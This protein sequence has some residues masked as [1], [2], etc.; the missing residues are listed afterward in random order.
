MGSIT[1]IYGLKVLG[2]LLLFSSILLLSPKE[3][4]NRI[5]S[6]R[7]CMNRA[8]ILPSEAIPESQA[9]TI[10]SAGIGTDRILDRTLVSEQKD[11]LLVLIL[12][13]VL[14]GVVPAL[15][16]DADDT[17]AALRTPDDGFPQCRLFRPCPGR[18]P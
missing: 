16:R 7:T 1:A 4:K 6:Y 18:R 10:P 14:R 3:A 12:G 5:D 13:D 8:T 17:S 15:G 9:L 2:G 11:L